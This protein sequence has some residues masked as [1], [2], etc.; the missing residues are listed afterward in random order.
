MENRRDIPVIPAKHVNVANNPVFLLYVYYTLENTIIAGIFP[1]LHYICRNSRLS[2]ENA[3]INAILTVISL[4]FGNIPENTVNKRLFVRNSGFRTK[5]PFK[6]ENSC[7]T[8]NM[9]IFGIIGIIAI[10]PKKG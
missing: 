4:I 5:F 8:V 10:I 7:F 3:G 1:Y 6:H 2:A 9:H